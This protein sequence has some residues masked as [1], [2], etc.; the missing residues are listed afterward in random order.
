MELHYALGVGK[1]FNWIILTARKGTKL[2]FMATHLGSLG[3]NDLFFWD[4]PEDLEAR[5]TEAISAKGWRISLEYLPS[6][7]SA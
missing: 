4:T 1:V 3:P 7:D 5:L 6:E 2:E